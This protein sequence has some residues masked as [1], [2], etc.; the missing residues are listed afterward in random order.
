MPIH[1]RRDVLSAI[2]ELRRA[3]EDAGRDPASI[4]V[5]VFGVPDD[6]ATIEAY[7]AAG[8]ERCLLKVPSATADVV[9]PIIDRYRSLFDAA[10]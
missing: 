5:G 1:G 3:A 2:T 8:V 7:R 6:H 10:R 9:F 4:E